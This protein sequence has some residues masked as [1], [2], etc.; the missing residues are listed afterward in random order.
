MPERLEEVLKRADDRGWTVTIIFTGPADGY[1]RA[2][3]GDSNCPL[4]GLYT[5]YTGHGFETTGE[6]IF[7]DFAGLIRMIGELPPYGVAANVREDSEDA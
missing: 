3:R 7:N 4:R 2:E 1:L 5:P 6:L